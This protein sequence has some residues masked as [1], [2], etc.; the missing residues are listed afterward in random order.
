MTYFYHLY[1]LIALDIVHFH[2]LFGT[3][4]VCLFSY[5]KLIMNTLEYNSYY[6][7]IT[8]YSYVIKYGVKY[9]LLKENKEEWKEWC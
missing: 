2:L 1:S 6:P 4:I 7:Y 3:I 5:S 9:G 8:M